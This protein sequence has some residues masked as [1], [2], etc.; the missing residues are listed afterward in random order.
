MLPLDVETQVAHCTPSQWTKPFGSPFN[1]A[2]MAALSYKSKKGSISL[3]VIFMIFLI[4][5]EKVSGTTYQTTP[6][7]ITKKNTVLKI[8]V[9]SETSLPIP[10]FVPR[11]ILEVYL[12]SR[13]TE[14]CVGYAACTAWVA[15]AVPAK[16][17]INS[18]SWDILRFQHPQEYAVNKKTN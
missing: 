15:A 3:P 9:N 12:T 16:L 8:E 2:T 5:F 1:I 6:I 4:L 13:A 7:T 14:A 17:T 10:L 11:S 18:N